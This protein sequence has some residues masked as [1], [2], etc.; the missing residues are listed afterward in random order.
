MEDLVEREKKKWCDCLLWD[1]A[2]WTVVWEVSRVS[3]FDLFS[4]PLLPCVHCAVFSHQQEHQA[5][6]KDGWCWKTG[7]K[8]SSTWSQAAVMDNWAASTY[9]GYFKQSLPAA[10]RAVLYSGSPRLFTPF[11]GLH[12][13]TLL[14][15]ATHFH[16]CNMW[17]VFIKSDKNKSTERRRCPRWTSDAQ[18]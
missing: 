11:W 4:S 18:R 12:N 14:F 3:R 10:L 6:W 1:S 2:T 17:T 16:L 13:N 7:R 15:L 9:P 5:C 8:S